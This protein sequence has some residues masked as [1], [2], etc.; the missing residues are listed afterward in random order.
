MARVWTGRG[1]HTARYPTTA[2]YIVVAG[3]LNIISAVDLPPHRDWQETMTF[4]LS[5]F[6]CR[7][8]AACASTVFGIA[9]LSRAEMLHYGAYSLVCWRRIVLWAMG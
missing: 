9:W 7:S 1:Q 3:L 8:L 6:R 5:R 2:K 4:E